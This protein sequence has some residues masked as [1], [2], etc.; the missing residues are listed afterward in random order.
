[1]LVFSSFAVLHHGRPQWTPVQT[2]PRTY[3]PEPI[4]TYP[5][6][7]YPP[8]QSFS[9]YPDYPPVVVT[10]VYPGRDRANAGYPDRGAGNGTEHR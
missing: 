4:P 8:N 6:T 1:M 5:Q 10:P 9:R 2:T 3:F 7:I